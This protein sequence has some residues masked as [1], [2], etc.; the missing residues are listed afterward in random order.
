MKRIIYFTAGPVATSAEIIAM[1][2]FNAV[3]VAP[4]DVIAM[5]TLQSPNYGAGIS[6][7][8][9]VAGTIPSAYSAVPVADPDNPPVPSTPLPATSAVVTNASTLPIQNSAGADPHNVTLTVAA[10]AV[11]AAVLAASVAFVDN[12]DNLTIQNSAGTA[13]AGN[14]AASVTAGVVANVKLAATVA[15]VVSGPVTMQNSAGTAIAGVHN[16]TVAAG[17]LSNVK[18]AATVAPVVSGVL[19]G[20]VATGTGTTVTVTVANGLVTAVALS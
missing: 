5:N 8:D 19:A 11:T 7:A 13:V 10:N 12:G 6:P 3:A 20:I 15:P 17:V 2:K 1:N 4:F 18:L 14:H 9:Y 16:A